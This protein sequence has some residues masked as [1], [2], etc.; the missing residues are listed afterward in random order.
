MNVAEA[1]KIAEHHVGT[2]FHKYAESEDSF[3]FSF[4]KPGEVV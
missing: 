4:F 2:K 3:T 1:L